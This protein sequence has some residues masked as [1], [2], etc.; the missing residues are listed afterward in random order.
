[1]P[2]QWLLI[3]LGSRGACTLPCWYHRQVCR[4][5]NLRVHTSC[6]VA[7]DR[8]VL[9]VSNHVSWLDIPALSSVAP[10]SFIA[11]KEVD[12]WPFVGWLAR[13]QR[14]LFIDRQRRSAVH[15]TSREMMNRLAEGDHLVLFAEGTS[16]DGN[17]VL[18]FKSSLF[19]AAK[20]GAAQDKAPDIYV[21][22]FAVAYTRLHGLPLGR[23]QM[24][25]VA[26][27]G[28]ME[29]LNHA[30]QI[31]KSGPVDVHVTVGEPIPLDEFSCRK[32]LA[33]Y[34]EQKIRRDFVVTTRTGGFGLPDAEL[35][36][37]PTH[38]VTTHRNAA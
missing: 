12:G 7:S 19:G 30:W 4:L 14:C 24:P 34:V 10:I 15:S 33:R 18:P 17:R 31:L 29:M 3:R 22:T 37:S 36:Q 20:P 16:S 6:S 5:L 23:A 38:T 8:P 1:M 21:Q 26:W 35:Q 11:K 25:R 9:I 32:D 13:L 2:V 27:Y 28:D